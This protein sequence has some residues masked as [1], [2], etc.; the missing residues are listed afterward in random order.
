M[1]RDT[2]DLSCPPVSRAG[3]GVGGCSAILRSARPGCA[4]SRR[5]G[6]QHRALPARTDGGGGRHGAALRQ[7]PWSGSRPGAPS[8]AARAAS[9]S[10]TLG[11]R[12]TNKAW[13]SP[14]DFHELSGGQLDC[15]VE[16]CNF[17][18]LV[19]CAARPA[20]PLCRPGPQTL[21]CPSPPLRAARR[22]ACSP[23]FPSGAPANA[24]RVLRP[25]REREDRGRRL[26]HQRHAAPMLPGVGGRHQAR[27]ATAPAPTLSRR[28][29]L[30]PQLSLSLARAAL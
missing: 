21:C 19:G 6:G 3:A 25:Q 13:V 17:I 15:Y 8:A 29:S 7:H 11:A 24:P 26:R 1:R 12:Q 14:A 2:L 4:E 20:R 18:F 27:C 30:S 9:H 22:P 10:R 16:Y 23:R 28:G 5:G